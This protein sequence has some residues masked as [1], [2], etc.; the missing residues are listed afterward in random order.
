MA[1]KK[2]F[3]I[4]ET[5]SEWFEWSRSLLGLYETEKQFLANSKSYKLSFL[6]M[7]KWVLGHSFTGSD[8]LLRNLVISSQVT[9]YSLGSKKVTRQIM[10]FLR[11]KRR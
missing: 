4:F 5:N 7:R 9:T 6:S 2:K 8:L 11:L 10:H 3:E 1:I